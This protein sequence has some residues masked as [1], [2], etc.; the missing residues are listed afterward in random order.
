MHA[1]GRVAL[2]VPSLC[3][4]AAI[5]APAADGPAPLLKPVTP[6]GGYLRVRI[7]VTPGYPKTMSFN[8]Q[9]PNGK[10][11]GELINATVALETLPGQS[12]VA[13]KKLE[14]WGYDVPKN[15]EFL[16]PELLLPTAQI[17]P[18]V[19]KGG[20]DVTVRLTNVKLTVV[21]SPAGKDDTIFSCDM[22]LSATG[23]YAGHEKA[24]EPRLSFADK[25]LELTVP[26]AVV[27][28]PGTDALKIPEP[29]GKPDATLVPAAAPLV[30]RGGTPAIA[31]AAI[32]GRE[33]YKTPDGKVIPVSIAVSSITNMPSGVLVTVGLQRGCKIEADQTAKSLEGIGVEG[34]PE[35]MPGKIKELRIGLVTGPGL[36][37]QK[38]IVIKDLPVMVDKNVSEGYMLIGQKFID[39]YF[40]DGVYAADAGVWKLHG[41]VNPELLADVKTRPKQK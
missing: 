1:P 36:K 31:Y 19:N 5:A 41:R 32:N 22:S 27:K 8:A 15:K 18:K 38:D 2:L 17:A 9:L 11:K 39:T 12:Y 40:P 24:M 33:S 21:E 6:S 34:R 26:A 16:L 25:F 35:F 29:T 28:R 30:N 20:T 37:T 23:L 3:L 13:A 10:K 7:P 14:S 4:L